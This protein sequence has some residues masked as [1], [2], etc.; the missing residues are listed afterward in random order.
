MRH[1][2]RLPIMHQGTQ[3]ATAEFARFNVD[4]D[5]PAMGRHVGATNVVPFRRLSPHPFRAL[6][7]TDRAPLVW[8]APLLGWA[9]RGERRHAWVCVAGAAVLFGIVVRA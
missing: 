7:T 9:R 1:P 5:C 4:G 3:W 2:S 6:Q 8:L